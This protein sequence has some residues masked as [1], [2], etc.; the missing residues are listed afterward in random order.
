MSNYTKK[1]RRERREQS[2]QDRREREQGG[3]TKPPGGPLGGPMHGAG[4]R[5]RPSLLTFPPPPCSR[6]DVCVV[7]SLALTL[8][9]LRPG[10]REANLPE[11][12]NIRCTPEPWVLFEHPGVPFTKHLLPVEA[13]GAVRA[14]P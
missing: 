2:P 4:E 10:A 14:M 13:F 9:S 3:Y 6:L 12:R 5:G 11:E 7:G 1:T 8:L